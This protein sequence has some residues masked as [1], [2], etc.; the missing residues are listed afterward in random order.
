MFEQGDVD[1]FGEIIQ[2]MSKPRTAEARIRSVLKL[3]RNDKYE[4]PFIA[5]FR[6]EHIQVIC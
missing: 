2:W 4:V 3:I 1:E 5:S 6:K